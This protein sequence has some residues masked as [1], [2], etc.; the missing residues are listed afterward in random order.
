MKR[1]KL[2]ETFM[3]ISN[4]EHVCSV[5]VLYCHS[6]PDASQSSYREHRRYYRIEY[7]SP[8][9]PLPSSM[10][11]RC[12]WDILTLVWAYLAECSPTVVLCSAIY[13]RWFLATKHH[14][15]KNSHVPM[16]WRNMAITRIRR[17]SFVEILA[18]RGAA[19]LCALRKHREAKPRGTVAYYIISTRHYAI[20]MTSSRH[21]HNIV[22]PRHHHYAP[23]PS[24]I[25]CHTPNNHWPSP[26]LK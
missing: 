19:Q 9:Y 14:E 1:K 20:A 13:C 18:H 25:F 11:R 7:T 2:T 21:H 26:I 3:M 24:T 4:W 22:N 12:V 10:C 6:I 16:A 5:G 17:R 15:K 23:D 8:M